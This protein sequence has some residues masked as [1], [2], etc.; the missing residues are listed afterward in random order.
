MLNSLCARRNT[1]HIIRDKFYQLMED[2]KSVDLLVMEMRKQVKDCQ[3]GDVRE[4]LML[5]LLI[6]DIIKTEKAEAENLD[7]S[8]AI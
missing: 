8:L 7:L 4:E 1:C 5:H 3:F 2:G 6:M